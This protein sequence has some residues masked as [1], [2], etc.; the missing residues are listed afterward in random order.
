VLAGGGI[1]GRGLDDE[2]LAETV[3]AGSASRVGYAAD[4]AL[5]QAPGVSLALVRRSG[6]VVAR[7]LEEET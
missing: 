1:L 7:C 3:R 5:A 6:A 2:G 4:M